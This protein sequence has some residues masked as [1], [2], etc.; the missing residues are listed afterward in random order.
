MANR[1][2]P[3]RLGDVIQRARCAF[4]FAADDVLAGRAV[5]FGRCVRLPLTALDPGR[6]WI[7]YPHRV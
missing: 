2:G 7:G 6:G 5:R 4:E 1:W 3:T